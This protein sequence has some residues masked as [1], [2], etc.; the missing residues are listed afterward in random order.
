[1][2]ALGSYVG[3]CGPKFE[4]FWFIHVPVH[5]EMNLLAPPTITWNTT[6]ILLKQN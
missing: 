1:M 6:L 5:S 4:T 2:Y 3:W